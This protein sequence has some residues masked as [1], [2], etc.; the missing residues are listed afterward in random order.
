M[1]D[2]TY[3][4]INLPAGEYIGLCV[5]PHKCELCAIWYSARRL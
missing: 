1:A 3:K 2:S 5:I 4:A